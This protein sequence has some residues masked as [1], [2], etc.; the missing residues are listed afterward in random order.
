MK[1]TVGN[2]KDVGGEVPPGGVYIGRAGRGRGGCFGN[3][4]PL[5]NGSFGERERVLAQYREH[6]YERLKTDADFASN[7]ESCRGKTLWCFCSPLPCH[8]DII[9]EFL[10]GSGR[11]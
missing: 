3:P 4:F 10:N 11:E 8:G 6:F 1:T 7:V 5:T 2:L 9:A